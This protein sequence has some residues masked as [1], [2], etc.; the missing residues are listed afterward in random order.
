MFACH[1]GIIDL[2]STEGGI[3]HDKYGAYAILLKD[4]GEIEAATEDTFTYRCKPHETGKYRLT[5]ATRK[6][7]GMDVRVLR[8]H[9]INSIWSPRV[10]VR[11]E[12][13]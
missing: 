13:L 4:T 10:G 3:S 2:E 12:G 7:R 1:A 5:S 9:S 8:S 11:Y 6:T